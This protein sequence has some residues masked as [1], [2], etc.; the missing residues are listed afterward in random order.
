MKQKKPF[1]FVRVLDKINLPEEY[2]KRRKLSKA[3]HEEIKRKYKTGQYS[4][5]K[6]GEMYGVAYGTIQRLTSETARQQ[7]R[8][9]NKKWRTKNKRKPYDAMELRRRKLKLAKDGIIIIN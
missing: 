8:E 5:K 6:L 4:R 9:A 1:A 3:K 2:D 7:M